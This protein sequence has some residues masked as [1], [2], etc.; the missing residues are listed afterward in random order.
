MSAEPSVIETLQREVAALR[1]E[2]DA[3]RRGLGLSTVSGTGPVHLRVASLEIVSE[4][5]G[6]GRYRI[7]LGLEERGG[8]LHFLDAHAGESQRQAALVTTAEGTSLV[9]CGEDGVPRAVLSG[10]PS[11]GGLSLVDDN[12]DL[13]AE[14]YG[15]TEASWL[16]LLHDGA[17][18]AVSVAA[19][20]GGNLELFDEA[21]NP[22]VVLPAGS[23][24]AHSPE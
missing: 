5:E 2:L 1:A 21:A 9:L 13:A 20:T 14:L 22:R 24:G 11:G 18:A 23:G 6:N 7:T 15:T 12:H 16:C 8:A 19:E 10:R 3:L 4:A 17:P